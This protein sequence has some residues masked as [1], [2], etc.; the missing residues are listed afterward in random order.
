VPSDAELYFLADRPNL[1]RFYNT[2][3]GVR[4][5]RD[6]DAVLQTLVDRPPRVITFRTND[7]Y[8]TAASRRIMEYVRSTYEQFDTVEQVEL[9]RPRASNMTRHSEGRW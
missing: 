3:L 2:A 1:F 7:K 8:N 4:T 5:E 9:Y 6:V